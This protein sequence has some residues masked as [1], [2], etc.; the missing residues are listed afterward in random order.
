M[1]PPNPSHRHHYIPAFYLKRWCGADG[2]LCQFSRPYQGVVANRRFPKQTGFVE[3]LYEITGLPGRRTDAAEESFFKP[4]DSAAADALSLLEVDGNAASWDTRR[5]S[6]WS[7]FLH[8]L[9]LRCPEDLEFF[10][11]D[12]RRRLLTDP[13]GEWGRKYLEIRTD[14]DPITLLEHM[15]SLSEPAVNMSA[16]KALIGM[17]DNR[18]VGEKTNRM[19][20]RIIDTANSKFDLMTSDRPLIRTNG[21][22]REGGHM[23]LAIGP[24]R[25]FIAAKDQAALD[26]ILIV[27]SDDLVR[28]NNRQVVEAAV[29]YVYATNDDQVRFVKNRMSASPQPRILETMSLQGDDDFLENPT[30]SVA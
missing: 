22:L 14:A 19:L 11:E 17:I 10:R 20:W 24:R 6:G 16:M 5:R 1:S 29:K 8:S 26:A 28:E 15:Q 4:A 13:S 7:R 21:I 30:R 25:L 12:W 3:R 2:R 23:A 18:G 9:L 27:A